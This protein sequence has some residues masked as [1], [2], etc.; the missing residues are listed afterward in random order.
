[1]FDGPTAHETAQHALDHGAQR[2][3]HLREPFRIHM[4]KLLEVLLDQTK[5]RQLSRPSRAIDPAGEGESVVRAG[6][7]RS[8][9]GQSR[10]V[11]LGIAA[12]V[13]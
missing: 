2:A 12:L 8:G 1:M 3:V 11:G 6:P 4:E 5:M 7:A 9:G 13:G 10:V